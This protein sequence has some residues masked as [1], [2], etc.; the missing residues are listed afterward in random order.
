[1]NLEAEGVREEGHE[2]DPV[3]EEEAEEEVEREV[4]GEVVIP[5]EEDEESLSLIVL[6]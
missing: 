3:E 4:V 6:D 1:M 2:G 5:E